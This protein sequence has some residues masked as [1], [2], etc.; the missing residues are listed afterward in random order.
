[1]ILFEEGISLVIVSVGTILKF[2]E[3]RYHKP[4]SHSRGMV[5]GWLRK[6]LLGGNKDGQNKETGPVI[7]SDHRGT[8]PARADHAGDDKN[9]LSSVVKQLDDS[10]LFETATPKVFVWGK[11]L[12][13]ADSEDSRAARQKRSFFW[14]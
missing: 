10:K 6:T 14:I 13:D 1:M 4:S 2:I 12:V 11:G 5:L 9:V 3:I 8:T 7:T